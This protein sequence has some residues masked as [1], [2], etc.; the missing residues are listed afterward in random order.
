MPWKPKL[1]DP[2][3]ASVPLYDS[4]VAVTAAPLWP[5]FAF[6][7]L[8]TFWLPAKV[9]P[10]DQPEVAAPLLVTVTAAVKPLPQSFC[11]W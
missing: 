3:V 6:Q 8:V 5:T 7:L 1:A 10:S 11:T 2:P 9:Q 4:L